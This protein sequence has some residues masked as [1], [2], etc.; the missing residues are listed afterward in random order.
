MSENV[1][2]ARPYAK[3]AF[4]LAKK[5]G[6]YDSWSDRLAFLNAVVSD[7]TVAAALDDPANTA[8]DR[9]EL[10]KKIAGD[11]L[12]PE[13]TNMVSLLSENNRLSLMGEIGE[14]YE[15]LRAEE[16]GV[17]DANVTSAMA[18]DD[19]Y[20]SKLAEALQRKF[21]KKINI[22]ETIDDSLIGGAI[23]RAGD[24]VIDGSIKGRLAQLNSN[25]GSR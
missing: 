8:A 14:M 20:K 7:K 15:E 23:V 19:N 21:N 22:I 11:R 9:A 4:E 10:V 18:L 24:V 6:N 12:D 13:S 2:A 5:G 17:L 25:L 1:T 16:E 3:A